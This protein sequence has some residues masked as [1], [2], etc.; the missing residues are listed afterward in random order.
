MECIVVSQL[1][2]VLLRLSNTDDETLTVVIVSLFLL[3]S[4]SKYFIVYIFTEQHFNYVLFLCLLFLYFAE[5]ILNKH[6][7][8]KVLIRSSC[9]TDICYAYR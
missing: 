2:L 6:L 1:K 9:L 5:H 8:T 4:L 3:L 7:Y